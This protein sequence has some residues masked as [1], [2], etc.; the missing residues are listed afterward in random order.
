MWW[1]SLG[2]GLLTASVVMLVLLLQRRAALRAVRAGGM[3]AAVPVTSTPALAW[4]CHDQGSA[5]ASAAAAAALLATGL[6]GLFSLFYARASLRMGPLPAFLVSALPCIAAAS[7][8]RDGLGGG[9][10][11]AAG[12]SALMLLSA[13][14]MPAAPACGA[15]R[16]H[17]GT[18]AALTVVAAAT[19]TTLIALLAPHARP[20]L[21]GM[22]AANP[23]IVITT[24]VPLHWR[25][26]APCVVLHLRGYV[27]GL[28]AKAVFLGVLAS[29]L[30]ACAPWLAW[31]AALATGA[32]TA[33]LLWQG[34]GA[35]ATDRAATTPL[36]PGQPPRP[37]RPRAGVNRV[38]AAQSVH[39]PR[40]CA[41][42]RGPT[43]HET[44]QRQATCKPKS[45]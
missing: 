18:D 21:C 6:T 44:V 13:T 11:P 2:K 29:L 7:L 41:P 35:P 43:L 25:Q 15:W 20:S 26:G 37:T 3:L 9:L 16:A 40:D 12:M 5:Y 30:L 10:L 31:V 42:A 1:P 38:P 45:T 8:L 14:A 24:V 27:Q 22:L 19:C 17:R 34:R 39:P 32:A 23:V 4:M 36:G 28:W 33:A